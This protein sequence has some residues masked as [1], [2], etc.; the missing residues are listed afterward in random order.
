M[1]RSARLKATGDE[2]RRPTGARD[3]F[4]GCAT[5]D[6]QQ[7]FLHSSTND[8]ILGTTDVSEITRLNWTEP[9]QEQLWNC[10]LTRLRRK[11]GNGGGEPASPRRWS[12]GRGCRPARPDRAPYCPGTALPAC[13]RQHRAARGRD[14]IQAKSERL[15][16]VSTW[17]RGAVRWTR[18]ASKPSGRRALH[19]G[20]LERRVGRES[21]EHAISPASRGSSLDR[22]PARSRAS[23]SLRPPASPPARAPN[24]ASAERRRA[25]AGH[26]VRV[27]LRRRAR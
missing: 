27:L 18:R 26:G 9:Q 6:E 11:T 21:A 14:I 24:P 12:T 22:G 1:S 16:F 25:G 5:I 8:S 19:D 15:V 4:L 2:I 3:Q 20:G 23:R 10:V 7:E 13:G 17:S